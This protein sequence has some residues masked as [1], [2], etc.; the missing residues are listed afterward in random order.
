MNL[1]TSTGDLVGNVSLVAGIAVDS[2]DDPADA[3]DA[4][5]DD[6]TVVVVVEFSGGDVAAEAVVLPAS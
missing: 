4:A 1:F 5:V 6:A 3:T 2:D